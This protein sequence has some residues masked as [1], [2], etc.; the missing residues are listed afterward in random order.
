MHRGVPGPQPPLR[1]GLAHRRV[2]RGAV[3]A[4]KYG[5]GRG[6]RD[7]GRRQLRLLQRAARRQSR[8]GREQSRV[9]GR[10]QGEEPSGVPRDQGRRLHRPARLLGQARRHEGGIRFSLGELPEPSLRVRERQ[11]RAPEVR[12]GVS[13]AAVL[14]RPLRDGFRHM[15]DPRRRA[16][17]GDGGKVRHRPVRPRSQSHAG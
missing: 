10:A 13:L 7:E 9:S 5:H 16:R 2:L 15:E 17:A 6:L 12:R 14:R 3:G 1:R 8:R 11:S 4:G